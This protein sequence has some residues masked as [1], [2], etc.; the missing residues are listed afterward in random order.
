MSFNFNLKS[1][2]WLL[3]AL[4]YSTTLCNACFFGCLRWS[5]WGHTEFPFLLLPHHRPTMKLASLHLESFLP[6][7]SHNIWLL[8]S[9]PA[10]CPIVSNSNVFLNPDIDPIRGHVFHN[11]LLFLFPFFMFSWRHVFFLISITFPTSL[12]LNLGVGAQKDDWKE[13]SSKTTLLIRKRIMKGVQIISLYQKVGGKK[14]LPRRKVPGKDLY[15]TVNKWMFTKCQ[16]M[17]STH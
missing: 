12:C 6:F 13:W 1:H 14:K 4:L 10:W 16:E 9:F 5:S 3:S 2:L 7:S 15:Q 8:F 17:S 11:C